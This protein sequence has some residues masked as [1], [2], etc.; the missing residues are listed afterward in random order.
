MSDVVKSKRAPTSPS[1]AP[2]GGHRLARPSLRAT[3]KTPTRQNR[4]HDPQSARVAVPVDSDSATFY[5]AT[6]S[7]LRVGQAGGWSGISP[8]TT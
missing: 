4:G 5:P 7:R 2:S 6:P 3:P 8:V 1:A